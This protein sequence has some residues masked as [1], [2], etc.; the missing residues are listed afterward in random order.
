MR[1]KIA[2]LVAVNMETLKAKDDVFDVEYVDTGSV[3]AG[4]FGPAEYFESL[5]QAPSRARRVAMAGDTV[6]S[7]VR[8]N[9]R[10]FGFITDELANRVYST[11]FAVLHPNPEKVLPYYF[12]LI[13]NQEWV[14]ETLHSIGS[15]STSA[16]PSIKPGDILNLEVEVPT[17]EK[18]RLI[19]N[20]FQS[21]DGKML[22]NNQINDNLVA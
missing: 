6:Y 4:V 14:T 7:T 21:L 10:H 22:I 19:V 12:Y 5:Q 8:P 17:L 1:F 20:I 3:T 11:G 16:Y 18:Q 15:G 13:M 2:D 9:Q